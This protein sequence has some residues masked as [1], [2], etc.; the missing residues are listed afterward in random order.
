MKR[1]LL[2][3]LIAAVSLQ[4]RAGSLPSGAYDSDA[5]VY[6]DVLVANSCTTPTPAFKLAVSHYVQAEKVAGNWNSQ[7]GQ[8]MLATA[9]SCTASINLAQ[10]T[11]YKITYSGACTFAVQTGLNGVERR[12]L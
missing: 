4:A 12:N 8:Y 2:S 11:L 9:D 3:L 6:F 10:P 1:V 7:D 5:Q